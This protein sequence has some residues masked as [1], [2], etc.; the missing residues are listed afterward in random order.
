MQ[1]NESQRNPVN[2]SQDHNTV[3]PKKLQTKTQW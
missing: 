2:E 1:S 3:K